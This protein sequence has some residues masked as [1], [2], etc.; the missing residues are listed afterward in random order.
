ML[1]ADPAKAE[2][3]MPPLVRQVRWWVLAL[4]FCVTVINF[5]DRQS[6]SIVAPI[7]RESLKLSNT[8]YGVIVSAFL[9]GMMVGEFPMGR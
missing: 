5:V 2:P 8:D 6:L 4:I 1:A 7:L 3:G 9:T